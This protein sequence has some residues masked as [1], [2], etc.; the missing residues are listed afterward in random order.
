M[1]IQLIL[2]YLII[3]IIST[4]K[5]LSKEE[6]TEETKITRDLPTAFNALTV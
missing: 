4:H 1:I 2:K 6:I 5:C 3:Y